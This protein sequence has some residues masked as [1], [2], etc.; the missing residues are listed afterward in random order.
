[1]IKN[2][3]IHFVNYENEMTD[4]FAYYADAIM[5]DDDH[6][7]LTVRKMPNGYELYICTLEYADDNHTKFKERFIKPLLD[8]KGYIK[9]TNFGKEHYAQIEDIEIR[10]VILN[11][12]NINFEQGNGK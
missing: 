2:L 6:I 9:G 8:D 12:F 4:S 7:G 10:Y 5:F 1:M 11:E 3:V